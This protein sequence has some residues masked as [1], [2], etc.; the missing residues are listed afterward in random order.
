M[1]EDI[2]QATSVTPAP[3]EPQTLTKHDLNWAWFKWVTFFNCNINYERLTSSAMLT[4]YSQIPDKIYPN[5]KAKK[6]EFMKRQLEFFNTEPHFGSIIIGLTLSMEEERAKNDAVTPE[7]ITSVKTGLMGPF[8]GVGDTLWQGTITPI[9]LAIC[10]PVVSSGNPFGALLYAVLIMTAMLSISHFMF[11]TGYRSGKQGVE[12]MMK[13]GILSR[14]ISIA[15]IMGAIVLG[16]LTCNYVTATSSLEIAVGE[17]TI[18]LQSTLDSIL[19]GIVP[20]SVTLLSWYL[21]KIKNMSATKV[22]VI[23][24]LIGFVLGITGLFGGAA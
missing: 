15:T 10:M 4:A 7:A 3:N 22:L 19:I 8:A 20:L 1:S 24:A 12:S 23:L 13:S 11:F 6:I 21:L 5:N 14:V 2:E 18:S 9:L 17:G 16:C